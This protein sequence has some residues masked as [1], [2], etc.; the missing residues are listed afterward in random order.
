MNSNVVTAHASHRNNV[1][2]VDMI[3]KMELTRSTVKAN[4]VPASSVVRP[5]SVSTRAESVTNT[6]TVE[7]EVTRT[8]VVSFN[9][10]GSKY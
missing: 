6:L 1:A 7:M 4:V 10:F 2:T 9:V 3:A 5:A 8:I